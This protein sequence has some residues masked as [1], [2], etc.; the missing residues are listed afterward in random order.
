MLFICPLVILRSEEILDGG[1]ITMFSTSSFAK[2]P[3]SKSQVDRP[4]AV[5]PLHLMSSLFSWSVGI[6]VIRDSGCLN[7]RFGNMLVISALSQFTSMRCCIKS[8]GAVGSWTVLKPRST[9]HPLVFP[10]VGIIT[11]SP[12]NKI[13]RCSHGLA[14][15]CDD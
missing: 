6:V 14:K 2:L 5:T 9:N 11:R 8:W 4:L 3:S 12:P 13:A 15:E 7:S 1:T 10:I